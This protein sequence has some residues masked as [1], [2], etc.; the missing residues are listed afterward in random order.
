LQEFII[1]KLKKDKMLIILNSLERKV[2]NEW[3]YYY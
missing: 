1:S 2:K 3:Y